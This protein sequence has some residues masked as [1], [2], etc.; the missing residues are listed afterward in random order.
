M[1]G[2]KTSEEGRKGS[3]GSEIDWFRA[4]PACEFLRCPGIALR[5][6]MVTAA[7]LLWA[8]I[9]G[10]DRIFPPSASP[11]PEAAAAPLNEYAALTEL[12]ARSSNP[13]DGWAPSHFFARLGSVARV[14]A[15]MVLWL[16]LVCGGAWLFALL[17]RMAAF[18]LGREE[19][20]GAANAAR[21]LFSR[22]L[23]LLVGPGMAILAMGCL[24][25]WFL[26]QG[27]LL[28][29]P[30]AFLAWLFLPISA[31]GAGLLA[32]FSLGF[33]LAGPFS[34]SAVA[35]NGS[36][37]FDGLSRG[38]SY[39]T[40]Q[41]FR[42][43]GYLAAAAA[44]YFVGTACVTFVASA[45]IQGAIALI[46]MGLTGEWRWFVNSANLT[47]FQSRYLQ[48]GPLVLQ[49]LLGTWRI[50]LSAS[51]MTCLYLLRRRDIDDSPLDSIKRDEE[52]RNYELPPLQVDEQGVP[53]PAGVFTKD[54]Q[55][56]T[57]QAV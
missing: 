39:A 19:R 35:I 16:P 54:E 40:Q 11:L 28:R 49:V 50:S 53:Q 30:L 3:T 24:A 20:I 32:F 37:A 14:G 36:D 18:E 43:V 17:S 26:L 7:F 10:L 13:L 51:L 4:A 22:G 45:A 2:M 55:V 5:A 52:S 23:A 33:L 25:L 9:W 42:L 27:W 8:V 47:S 41:P 57:A 44:V 31:L 48:L 1:S 56:N 6:R 38:Y 29:G 21:F 46:G 12:F 34:L 15:W